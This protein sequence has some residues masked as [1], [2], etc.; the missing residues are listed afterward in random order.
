MTWFV[1][2]SARGAFGRVHAVVLTVSIFIG[3]LALE[4]RAEMPA[5]SHGPRGGHGVS[6]GGLGAGIAIGG[7]I[8]GALLS[9]RERP[10]AVEQ[11]APRAAAKPGK[12]LAPLKR[13]A[14]KKPKTEPACKDCTPLEASI[15]RNVKTL[16]D[17]EARL[18]A[19]EEYKR[20]HERELATLTDPGMQT[21]WREV[22]AASASR[23][24]ELKTLTAAV[25]A[26]L[27]SQ[28]SQLNDKLAAHHPAASQPPA[29]IPPPIPPL[30]VAG[31][32]SLG[33]SVAQNPPAP[34]ATP[35]NPPSATP[36]TPTPVSSSPGSEPTPIA[37]SGP[38][39][40]H[41]AEL[42]NSKRVFHRLYVV[43]IVNEQE[44]TPWL[45]DLNNLRSTLEAPGAQAAGSTSR[46]LEEPSLK[47]LVREIRRMTLLAKACEEVTLY[48]SG[49]AKGGRDSGISTSVENHSEYFPLKVTDSN[50]EILT[51]QHMGTLVKQF[52]ANVSVSVIFD[53]CYG[54]GF[55]G[56]G[57]VEET[58]LVK[59]LGN[60]TTCPS[61]SNTFTTAI[62]DAIVSLAPGDRDKRVTA[63]EIKNQLKLRHWPL[64]APFDTEAD[65][66]RMPSHSP[67]MSPVSTQ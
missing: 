34:P 56:K 27:Q 4:A 15:A 23:I 10:V 54:G 21:A 47:E 12:A 11:N 40:D 41:V 22:I 31:P 64:G 28:R 18:A 46:M 53:S 66:K 7:M 57:N 58:D 25:E 39:P 33:T 6:M 19:E 62:A 24:A 61:L 37:S 14:L 51:D 67:G 20:R 38:C 36:P 35:S 60:Y 13:Q 55:A 45:S 59:L 43:G 63:E 44:R 26:S 3:S 42:T 30:P 16:K 52:A 2:R 50:A 49:H 48:F 65:L 29:A 17:Q 5:G 8:G 32:P 1:G 9:S